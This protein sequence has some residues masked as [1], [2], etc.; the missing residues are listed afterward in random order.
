MDKHLSAKV[1]SNVRVSGRLAGHIMGWCPVPSL[2]PEGYSACVCGLGGLL[3]LKKNVA[4]LSFTQAE[5]C[6]CLYLKV[7]GDKFQ[8]PS[9]GPS[10]LL[11]PFYSFQNFILDNM[12]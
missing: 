6:S 1:D 12:I 7:I 10:Y 4:S 8:L 5:L 3:D 2:T 9:L 11:P